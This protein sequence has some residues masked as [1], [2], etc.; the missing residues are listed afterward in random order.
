MQKFGPDTACFVSQVPNGT[1]AH[2]PL[3]RE[4]QESLR[5]SGPIGTLDPETPSDEAEA[6]PPSLPPLSPEVEPYPIL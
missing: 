3:R 2:E 5:L 6:Q 1:T 4:T